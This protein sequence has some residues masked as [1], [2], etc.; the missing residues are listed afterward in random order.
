MAN[1][2]KVVLVAGPNGAGKTTVAPLLLR[3]MLRV[4]AFVNADVI[5]Q[6]FCAFDPETQ[7]VAAGRVMLARLRELARGHRCFAFETTLASRT[8]VPWLRELVAE[9]YALHL[10]YVWVASADLAVRRV[11][12]RVRSGGHSVPEEVV[13]R[14]YPRSLENFF[15]LYSPLA[16]SRSFYDNSDTRPR[17]IDLLHE[18]NEVS[19][20]DFQARRAVSTR[21]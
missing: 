2:P 3:D 20:R 19:L 11:A 4:D 17:R 10:V 13:R 14:R 21:P 1:G 5:A 12:A 18:A 7:A 15:S 8:L 16:T 6:G 9:G